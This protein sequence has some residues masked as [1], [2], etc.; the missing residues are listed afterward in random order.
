MRSA[1][2]LL[3]ALVLAGCAAPAVNPTPPS[4]GA[5]P[6]PRAPPGDAPIGLA[7]R[8]DVLTA[9]EPPLSVRIAPVAR[10]GNEPTVA[11]TRDGS[12]FVAGIFPEAPGGQSLAYP[13]LRSR[14][15]GATWEP[16]GDPLSTPPRD[17]DPWIWA[18]AGTDRVFHVP[19]YIACSWLQYSDDAG[20]TWKASP[21][22]GCGLPAHDHQ[23]LTT[24][25]PPA[26]VRLGGYPSVAYYAYNA[27]RPGLGA[28]D[29]A[30]PFGSNITTPLEGTAVS[31]SLDGGATWSLGQNVHT[32]DP[33]MQGFVG[34]VAVAPDG[35]ALLPKGTC[36]GV[37][38]LLSKDA[39]TT[40]AL[41]ARVNGAG[42]LPVT[43]VDPA[44]AYDSD[45]NA[46]L[47]WPGRDGATYLA[48]S[49][50][51]GTTWDAPIRASPPAIHDTVFTV[52]EAGAPGRVA[53]AY[54]G[55]TAPEE[56]LGN[57]DPSYV[58]PDVVWHLWVTAST[59]AL[60]PQP[61]FTTLQA[62]PDDDP[63]QVGCLWTDGNLNPC[64]SGEFIGSAQ[65]EGRLYVA[66]VDNCGRCSDEEHS[67]DRLATVAILDQGPDLRGGYLRPLGT[68]EPAT[69]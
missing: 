22:A 50:D 23:K 57:K 30:D 65:H 54:E 66:Y 13:A 32:Y 2:A 62:T 63:V 48:V 27:F 38:V 8:E 43:L 4:H 37:D 67:R 36:D 24:G 45:G 33:C 35:A 61:T 29:P 14:D 11:V 51:G 16:V 52:L 1:S 55:T 34:R 42:M 28:F 20:A 49:R 64:R 6:S 41:V 59:D 46:Y 19:L 5:N 40:W 25:P 10:Q 17:Y 12:I 44:A 26:S 39:G 31:V 58:A 15:L 60:A 56:K 21:R 68:E 3:V 69:P 9:A 7:V 53:L 47:A 18:D